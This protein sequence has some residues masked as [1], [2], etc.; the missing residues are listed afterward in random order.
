MRCYARATLPAVETI[1]QRELRNQS[2]EVMRGLERGRSYRVTSHGR[3]V[4]VLAP[5]SRSAL[6]ELTLR[7]GS[8]QMSFPP[9]VELTQE[10][11]GVLDDLRAGL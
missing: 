11:L 4:G 10:V 2:G 5:L 1:T 3:P 6:E 9:G 7:E 8:Q